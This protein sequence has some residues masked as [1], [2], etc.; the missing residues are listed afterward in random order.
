MKIKRIVYLIESKFNQ[1]DYNR[2][3][4]EL[5]QKLG[6][7]VHAWDFTYQLRLVAY[8]NYSPSDPIEYKLHFEVRS[9]S[10]FYRL[11]D[12]FG[13][14]AIFL[15]L[16][17]LTPT[18]KYVFEKLASQKFKYGI[19][20][21]G[22]LPSPP[23]DVLRK[24]VTNML[25]PYKLFKKIK[26][27]MFLPKMS[28]D[29][30]ITG[31]RL[32]TEKMNAAYPLAT[33]VKA[34]SLDY[35]LFLDLE[36]NIKQPNSIKKY[37]VF[38]DEFVP[39]HPDFLYMGVRPDAIP[40][41]YYPEINAFFDSIEK[42]YNVQVIIAAH[43]RSNYKTNNYN[44]FENRE[45]FFGKTAELIKDSGLVLTH[46]STAKSFAVLLYKSIIFISSSNYSKRFNRS[47]EAAAK[48]VGKSPINI[49]SKYYLNT[50]ID[51][52]TKLYTDFIDKYV[53]EKGTV[54]KPTW[55]I[56]AD[57]CDSIT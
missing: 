46:G 35:D 7:E 41:T 53:K 11:I 13:K 10:D 37:T 22:Y 27:R 52:N 39:Y 42:F 8:N 28:P 24:I 18:S 49:S 40:E 34:H 56:F 9:R 20:S 50:E 25:H 12:E 44:P 21:I 5:L 32:S 55:E 33:L 30:V 47:I 48:S 15:C 17:G 16:F 31:G 26:D 4:F 2:F 45:I 1:R 23:N 29:F 36:R 43:P 54:H 3:G 57:Y 6:Y 38:L 51:V 14:N 19:A